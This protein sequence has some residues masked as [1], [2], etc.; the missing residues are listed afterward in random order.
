L[1][2]NRDV[3]HNG[4]QGGTQHVFLPLVLEHILSDAELARYY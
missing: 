4:P 2:S 1:A 3:I